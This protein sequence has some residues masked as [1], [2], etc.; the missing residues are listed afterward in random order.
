MSSLAKLVKD[1]VRLCVTQWA[2]RN[3]MGIAQP[4]L[5]EDLCHQIDAVLPG[6]GQ[7]AA[8]W[9][10]EW[11]SGADTT[12]AHGVTPCRQV[13]LIGDLA[14]Q[15]ETTRKLAAWIAREAEKQQADAKPFPKVWDHACTECI[16]GGP[17]VQPGFR[18]AVHEAK[19]IL[20]EASEYNP[21]GDPQSFL[22][23]PAPDGLAEELEAD[24][25]R[26]RT[27]HSDDC[28]VGLGGPCDCGYEA[29]LIA[30]GTEALPE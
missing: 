30:G 1:A 15:E 28:T 21:Q 24:A 11:Q 22:F 7:K 12:E 20:A 27:E 25:R 10:A 14:G 29:D 13:V 8:A 23:M 3:T 16:R 6:P 4:T 5:V 26:P 18:C 17:M 19:A 2:A 9:Q